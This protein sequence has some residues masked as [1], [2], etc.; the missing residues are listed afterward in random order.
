MMGKISALLVS[1]SVALANG[2]RADVEISNKPTSNMSCEAGLCTA[3]AQKAVLNAGDLATMLASGDVAVKTGSVA[4]DIDIDQPLQWTSTSRLTLDA[5]QSVTVKKQITVAEQGALTVITNDTGGTKGKTKTGEFIIVPEHGSVQFWD[6]GSS[7]II[8]GNS[9]TLV[10][11]I[12]TLASGIS[13]NPSGFYALAKPYDASVDGTYSSAPVGTKFFGLFS[14]LG[15]TISNV[16][17][18]FTADQ[19]VDDSTLFGEIAS[20]AS[21]RSVGVING[22]LRGVGQGAVEGLGL[23]ASDNFGVIAD[24]WASGVISSPGGDGAFPGGLVGGNYGTIMKSYSATKITISGGGGISAG[25][26][27]GYNQGTIDQ[28]YALASTIMAMTTGVGGGLVGYNKGTI[29]NTFS[30]AAVH[31]RRS[32]GEF[33]YF[34]GLIGENDVDGRVTS[35][36]AAG[37]ITKG[38]SGNDRSVFGGF[39]GFDGA[40]AGGFSMDYWDLNKGINDPSKGAGNIPN[41]PGLTGLSDMQ[42]KSRLP[43]G[44]DPKVWGS[45]PMINKGYPYLLALPPK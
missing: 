39:V 7:L 26:L 29:Q 28:S 8:D 41:D 6:L 1:V 10:G 32:N 19:P 23:L 36:F 40:K 33:S 11:N 38:H 13:A 17:V 34:G 2:A 12:K 20:G 45:D 27:A 22:V 21:I 35:S 44:F 42:L 14:G 9:Y 5:Q 43:M 18:Q 3:T 37:E 4:K 30:R 24:C 31:D 15:N 25:G 16:A